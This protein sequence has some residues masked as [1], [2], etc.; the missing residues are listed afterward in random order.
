MESQAITITLPA[1]IYSQ[2]KQQS[3]LMRRSIAEELVA[4][5]I[6]YSQREILDNEIEDELSQLDFLTVQELWQAAQMTVSREQTDYMQQL[7]EKQQCEGL[8]NAEN[9]Q[10]QLL[11]HFFNRVMLI[12]AKA[13]TLLKK[14][15]YNISSLIIS[16]DN[17]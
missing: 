15:G 3:Q 5:V 6:D 12:R 9:Q 11:S 10:A 2:V 4:V 8:T 1:P 13:A 7:V 16:T 17:E 14:H